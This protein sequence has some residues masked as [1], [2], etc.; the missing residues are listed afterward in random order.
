[1]HAVVPLALWALPVKHSWHDEASSSVEN[2]PGRQSV[3]LLALLP[4]KVPARQLPQEVPPIRLR[5]LPAVHSM[6]ELWPS[7][8]WN[9]PTAHASHEAPPDAD[10][11]LP[12]AQSEHAD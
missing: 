4:E 6:Q 12:A 11:K 5:N 2:A 3:Q 7:L 9:V 8:F 1:L 10:L